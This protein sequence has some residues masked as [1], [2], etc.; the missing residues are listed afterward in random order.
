M[1]DNDADVSGTGVRSPGK[2]HEQCQ[3]SSS[4]GAILVGIYIVLAALPVALAYA[5]GPGGGGS[6]AMELGKAAGLVGFALLALQVA[7]SA[8]LKPVDAPFGLDVVM[9]FHKSMAILAG[10]LLLLHPAL[11]A[12]GGYG[13][14]L[15]SLD[16]SWYVTVG[17]FTLALVVLVIAF[18]MFFQQLGIEYQL[19]RY[20]HKGAVLVVALGFVHG[21]W[22]GSDMQSVGL[23]TYWWLLLAMAVGLFAYR[24][25]YVP[26]W[27]RQKFEVA[28]VSAES[29]DTWTLSLE[30]AEGSVPAHLPGQF[31]FLRLDRPG[32]PSEEHPFTISSRPGRDVL[33]ATIKESGDFTNTIGQTRDG[34]GARLEAP[35]GRFSYQF[36]NP[37]KFLFI[38]G[39]VG[40]TP[41]HSMLGHL[42]DTGDQ[43][44]GVL[45]YGNKREEDILFRDELEKLPDHIKVAHVLSRASDDWDGYRGFVTRDIIRDEAAHVLDEADVYLC[46]PPVM[47][48]MV[49]DELRGLDVPDAR[50][51]YERFAL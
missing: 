43:R 46:G 44:P 19:W 37:R 8:R 18:A 41:I 14:H 12:A 33:T 1:A 29:H 38:A 30:P 22:S 47:M 26:L 2:L 27:G 35:Y 4:W 21:L 10:L 36:H 48:D 42:R 5:L 31:M 9:N 13:L 40:I 3:W 49:I 50:I 25:L 23:Q 20:A 6:F 17:K 16:V 32:R 15:F 24:N 45:I 34:D 51:H 28:D 7:L 39:G 11:L